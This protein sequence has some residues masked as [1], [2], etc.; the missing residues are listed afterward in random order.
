MAVCRQIAAIRQEITG[1][2]QHHKETFDG[3]KA[4]AGSHHE[5]RNDHAR[6]IS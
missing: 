2:W 5:H 3:A 4:A 1:K 6:S